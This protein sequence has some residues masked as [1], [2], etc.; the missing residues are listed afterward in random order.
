MQKIKQLWLEFADK[1][2]KISKWVREGGLFFLVSNLIT[3]V[4]GLMVSV[5][6]PAFAFMGTGAIAYYL[7]PLTVSG[8]LAGIVV[9]I[10][11]GIVAA[12]VKIKK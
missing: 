3:I 8:T 7:V 4:R 5:L 2:P 12:R 10:I 11:G 1:N 6:Q 9:G